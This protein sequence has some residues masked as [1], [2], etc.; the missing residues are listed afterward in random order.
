M[1]ERVGNGIEIVDARAICCGCKDVC[2]LLYAMNL[3]LA[4]LCMLLSYIRFQSLTCSLR[5]GDDVLC[6]PPHG[7]Q[8]VCSR[9]FRSGSSCFFFSLSLSPSP[10]AYYPTTENK[11]RYTVCLVLAQALQLSCPTHP[12]SR[13]AQCFG[14]CARF[15]THRR[16]L[17]LSLPSSSAVFTSSFETDTTGE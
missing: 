1:R 5:M 17:S 3:Q 14:R 12:G 2:L 15:H 4:R 7:S 8:A 16:S 9:P 11:E 13:K 10:C 6:F